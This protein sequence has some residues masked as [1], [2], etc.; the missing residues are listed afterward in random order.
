MSTTVRVGTSGWSYREWRGTYY[1]EKLPAQQQLEYIAGRL[2]TLE[3]NGSF[4]S[5]QRPTS[6]RSWYRRTPDDFVFAVKGHRY[7]THLRRL[8]EPVAPLANFF[9]SGVLEL[10]DKL[11]PVLWQ[12]PAAVA[13]DE[14]LLRDFLAALPTDTAS[15]AALAETRAERRPADYSMPALTVNRPLRHA[16]EVRH[17]SFRSARVVD[18][19]TEHG[20]ALVAADT[21]GLFPYFAETTT[22]FGYVRLHGDTELY[23]SP[24]GAE[25]LTK[26]AGRIRKWARHGDVYVYFDNTAKAAAPVDAERL[27]A[28]LAPAP[29][30]G[31]GSTRISP[32]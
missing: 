13:F 1:P 7:L 31:A 30:I 2:P 4:Y 16:I 20:V 26:W 10:G 21:A 32:L 29:V 8:R 3:V 14:G 11:G 6:Y 28:M 19:L 23:V 5:L 25:A 18:L 15:A 22:D 24:Y 27:A 17:E 12:L 9:A